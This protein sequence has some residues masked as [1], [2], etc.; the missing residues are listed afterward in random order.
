VPKDPFA[1]DD[2]GMRGSGHKLPC[3]V[4]LKS[5]ELFAHSSKPVRITKGGAGG[6]GQ[7]RR[8][9]RRGGVRIRGVGVAR[10]RTTSAGPSTGEHT[11]ERCSCMGR[12]R[13]RAAGGAGAASV[14]T[15]P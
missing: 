10:V 1:R 7:W 6:G 2:I 4:A 13:S 15:L 12:G 11:V 9:R 3:A 14:P 8:H 5:I